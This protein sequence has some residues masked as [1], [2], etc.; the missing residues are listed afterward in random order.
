MPAVPGATSPLQ[1]TPLKR[2]RPQTPSLQSSHLLV[3]AQLA[4]VQQQEL[5]G[6]PLRPPLGAPA[7]YLN[8]QTQGKPVCLCSELVGHAGGS[9]CATS[10]VCLCSLC[11]LEAVRSLHMCQI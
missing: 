9:S 4:L 8:M 6:C 10:L 2:M 5:P 7:L 11:G 1:Q 3:Q